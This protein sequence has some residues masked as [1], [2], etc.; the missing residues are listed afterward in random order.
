MVGVARRPSQAWAAVVVVAGAEAGVASP[1]VQ[2]W[3]E[4]EVALPPVQ[5]WVE[6]AAAVEVAVGAA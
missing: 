6:V 4:V 2:A 3:A 1:P 5:A